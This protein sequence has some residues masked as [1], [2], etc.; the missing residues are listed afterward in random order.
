MPPVRTPPPLKYFLDKYHR[1][2]NLAEKFWCF[3]APESLS[4][5][6]TIYFVEGKSIGTGTAGTMLKLLD[7]IDGR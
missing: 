5:Y 3:R 4:G 2:K 6:Q 1:P 7:D